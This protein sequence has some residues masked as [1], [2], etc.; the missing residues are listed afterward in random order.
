[1][2]GSARID[3]DLTVTGTATIDSGIKA[4]IVAASAFVDGQTTVTFTTPYAGDYTVLLT[5]RGTAPT[6][7]FKPAVVAQ[8]AN[9]FTISAGKKSTKSLAEVHWIAQAVGQ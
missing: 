9:G 1:M 5:A 4:G 2:N 8:D 6:K 3:G 7:R